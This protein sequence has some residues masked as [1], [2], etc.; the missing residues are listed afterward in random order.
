M[1][2]RESSGKRG[3]GSRWQKARVTYLRSNP[4]C[5]ICDKSGRVEEASV[6]DH[7]KPHKL[8]E[9]IASGDEKQIAEAR[10]LFWDQENWQPLCKH[11]HDSYK[12]QLEKSGTIAGCDTNGKPLDPNHPW[13]K[14]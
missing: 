12:Q 9:A 3:Y 14:K 4:L 13:N 1:T 11:C 6:V 7:I 5:I 2:D 10:K 8:S